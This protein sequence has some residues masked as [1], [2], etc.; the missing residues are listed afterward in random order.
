M[1]SFKK[2]SWEEWRV[3]GSF[4]K[5]ALTGEA[6]V[7]AGSTITAMD[8]NGDDATSDIVD[9]GYKVVDG[10]K[11]WG[12]VKN[13]AAAKSPYKMTFKIVTSLGNKFEVDVRV[14]VKEI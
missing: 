12:R 14:K 7:S 1:D 3:A 2:Q 4:S 6:A 8:K 10:T 9:A 11:L 5:M 13:G